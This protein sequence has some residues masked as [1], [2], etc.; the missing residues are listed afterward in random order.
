MLK[1]WRT[2]YIPLLLSV[3]CWSCSK[4]PAGILSE[5]EMQRVMTDIYLAEAM[6]GL[7]YQTYKSDSMKQALYESVFRKYRITQAEYDSSLMW[8]GRNMDIYMGVY[9]RMI[10]DLDK[11]V[12]ALGDVQTSAVADSRKDSV[13]IWPRR[14]YLTLMPE[15]LFNGTTFDI[16]P[17][18][19][20][21]S[22]SSFVLGVRVWGL[23][24]HM[25]QK[26]EIR[27]S[28][29]QGDTTIT[30]T[31]RIRKDGYHQT[32]LKSIAIKKVKRVY[33]SIRL[34]NG[35]MNYYKIYLDSLN[36][37]RYN[38]SSG[39]EKAADKPQPADQR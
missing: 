20:Y 2:Y 30:V 8:Y 34:D 22:G 26:P 3:C 9:N 32:T 13:D 6:I 38:Y 24:Q 29:D 35:G 36:L 27:I 33:G 25:K 4:T 15:A 39:F 18:D 37:M 28:V 7:D 19:P 14:P 16:R 31:D 23:E 11:R 1:E 10:D 12:E 5:K 17:D 21:P